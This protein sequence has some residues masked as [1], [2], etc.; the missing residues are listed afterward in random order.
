VW[1]AMIV[2]GGID[3]L[4]RN[5]MPR[6]GVDGLGWNRLSG[7]VSIACGEIHCLGGFQC[8]GAYS[9]VLGYLAE[10]GLLNR[11]CSKTD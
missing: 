10:L 1:G 2:W 8:L 11:A 6:G 3:C 9:H 4:E 5:G 7:V